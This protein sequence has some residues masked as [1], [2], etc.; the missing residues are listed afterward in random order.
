MKKLHARELSRNQSILRFDVILQH[1][2][3]NQQCLLHIRVFFGGKTKSPCFD[4]FIHWLIK[5]ITNTYR[6]HFSRSYENRS[7]DISV[8]HLYIYVSWRIALT[9]STPS[10]IISSAMPLISSGESSPFV[11]IYVNNETTK[12]NG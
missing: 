1:D 5:Q 6:N 2:R 11:I 7:K 3:P 12:I 10:F 8:M 4:L 9:V